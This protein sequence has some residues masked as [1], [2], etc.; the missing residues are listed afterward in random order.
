MLKTIRGLVLAVGMLAAA[1][2]TRAAAHVPGVEVGT[3]AR[4]Q[5]TLSFTNTQSNEAAQEASAGGGA[6]TI[7]FQGSVQTPN[8]CYDVT[9]SQRQ[10]GKRIIVTVTAAPTDGFCTQVITY[11]NYSGQL[12][13]VA[14][15]TYDFQLVQVVGGRSTTVLTREVTVS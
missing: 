11:N 1:G 6:G 10:R 12:S 14:P 2:G 9:A 4:D 5:G 15:G 13:G 8:P 3:W 7:R